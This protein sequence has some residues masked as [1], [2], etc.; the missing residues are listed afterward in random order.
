MG[1][2]T[3]PVSAEVQKR[4]RN[5][6]SAKGWPTFEGQFLQHMGIPFSVCECAIETEKDP[7]A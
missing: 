4:I 7:D 2:R 5:Y 1:L 3:E 6:D